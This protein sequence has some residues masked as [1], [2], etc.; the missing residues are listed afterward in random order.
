VVSVEICG[1]GGWRAGFGF[2][3]QRPKIVAYADLL[4]FFLPD[5]FGGGARPAPRIVERAGGGPAGRRGRA[6]PKRIAAASGRVAPAPNS[7]WKSSSRR[8]IRQAS[9][10]FSSSRRRRR[11][12]VGGGVP[13]AM[14]ARRRFSS[15]GSSAIFSLFC[16]RGGAPA[17][18][19]RRRTRSSSSSCLPPSSSRCRHDS[20]V[21]VRRIVARSSF[22][23]RRSCGGDRRRH[24]APP[25][26]VR[27]RRTCSRASFWGR[28]SF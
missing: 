15:S 1:K 28:S 20:V 3:L 17:S 26:V 10:F 4:S 18:P 5:L 8:I 13:G 27:W 21:G 11:L 22:C 9:V 12:L 19:R 6:D 16:G 14:R 7:Q 2:P 23:P 25:E 24:D